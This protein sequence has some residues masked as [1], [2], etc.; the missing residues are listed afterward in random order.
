M[1]QEL[2]SRREDVKADAAGVLYRKRFSLDRAPTHSIGRVTRYCFLPIRRAQLLETILTSGELVSAISLMSQ[3]P[4]SREKIIIVPLLASASA[5]H[6]RLAVG[7]LIAYHMSPWMLVKTPE[8]FWV[9][10]IRF[11]SSRIAVSET[12]EPDC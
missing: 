7:I 6:V 10:G 2:S 1:K 9:A 11:S 5:R 4:G 8:G 12:H 3:S